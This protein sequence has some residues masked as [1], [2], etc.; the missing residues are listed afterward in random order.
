MK[1]SHP[2]EVGVPDGWQGVHR[3]GGSTQLPCT[4]LDS[5]H[6][7][8]NT[9]VP[10]NRASGPATGLA[11]GMYNVGKE[12]TQHDTT[13]HRQTK[14]WEGR[15]LMSHDFLDVLLIYCIDSI[16]IRKICMRHHHHISGVQ[17]MQAK[18]QRLPGAAQVFDQHQR[19][20]DFST[21]GCTSDVLVHHSFSCLVGMWMWRYDRRSIPCLS[22]RVCESWNGAAIVLFL[23]K[24]FE[25]SR[26]PP[27][28]VAWHMCLG[29]WN[30]WAK[31]EKPWETW[32]Y[33][34]LYKLQKVVTEFS[35]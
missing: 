2:P 21:N 28:S 26:S 3:F 32:P 14:D 20:R 24:H 30:L 8:A 16:P 31:C 29:A 34:A 23:L 4:L 6:H 18:C 1:L 10:S 33:I 35:P 17:A 12:V 7:H 5:A 27:V 11:R 9:V 13:T 15:R 25:V 19:W 22:C